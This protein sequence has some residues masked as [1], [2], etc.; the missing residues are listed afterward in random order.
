M[1]YAVGTT[2]SLPCAGGLYMVD[3]RNPSRPTSPGCAGQDGYVHDAQCVFYNG[4]DAKYN[5]KEICFNYNEDTASSPPQ[6][7]GWSPSRV[8][9][10]VCS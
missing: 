5:G 6:P 1:I 8:L 2:R 9:T 3:V 10:D 4:P 7:E